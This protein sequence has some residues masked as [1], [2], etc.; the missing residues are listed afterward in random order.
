MN[1]KRGEF[2][3]DVEE[4]QCKSNSGRV[5]KGL[6]FFLILWMRVDLKKDENVGRSSGN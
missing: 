4:Q 6:F 1:F 3:M 5:S 2:F